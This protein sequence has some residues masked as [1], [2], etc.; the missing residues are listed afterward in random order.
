MRCVRA[1]ALFISSLTCAKAYRI[2]DWNMELLPVERHEL[3]VMSF[4]LSVLG[5]SPDELTEI[6]APA[7]NACLCDPDDIPEQPEASEMQPGGLWIARPHRG[8]LDRVES[9]RACADAEGRALCVPRCGA[10]MAPH[11]TAAG[12]SQ[13]R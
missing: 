2:A 10:D 4:D 7:G 12:T 6:M 3:E 5:Y 9:H 1:H 11:F 13:S 8:T